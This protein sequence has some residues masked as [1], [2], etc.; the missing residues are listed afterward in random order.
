[1]RL[2]FLL[3]VQRLLLEDGMEMWVFREISVQHGMMR[4]HLVIIS[5]MDL[6]FL[7]MVV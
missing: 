1:M 4:L 7:Q 5:G 6:D 2:D 3:M